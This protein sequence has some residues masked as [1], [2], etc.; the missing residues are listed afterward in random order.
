MSNSLDNFIRDALQEH[1]GVDSSVVPTDV[2]AK[3]DAGASSSMGVLPGHAVE[4]LIARG[5]MGVVYRARQTALE[6][7]VA[8]KVMTALADS[9]EKPSRSTNRHP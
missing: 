7:E 9:P 8:V 3:T 2:V 5:G 4:G 1:D 6:R